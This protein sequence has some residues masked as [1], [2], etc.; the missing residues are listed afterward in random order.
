MP[1]GFRA[2]ARSFSRK[3]KRTSNGVDSDDEVN[4]GA[5][6]Q[7]APSQHAPS[8]HDEKPYPIRDEPV[9]DVLW[10]PMTREW[11]SS[12]IL[13]PEI[14]EMYWNGVKRELE[15]LLLSLK[16]YQEHQQQQQQQQQGDE[17]ITLPDEIEVDF[18]HGYDT[19]IDQV[20]EESRK[21]ANRYGMS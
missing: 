17:S 2:F 4:D 7:R 15:V 19:F 20:S 3:E 8:Q 12:E 16:Q 5:P 13:L 1:K 11:R 14:E 18:V 9:D 21:F 6:S 10:N